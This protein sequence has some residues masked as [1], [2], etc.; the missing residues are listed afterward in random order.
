MTDLRGIKCIFVLLITLI[1][2]LNLLIPVRAQATFEYTANSDYNKMLKNTTT[3][4][5]PQNPVSKRSLLFLS[6]L[7]FFSSTSKTRIKP[8]DILTKEEALSIILNSAG[9]QQDAFLRA[10]KL[11]AKRPSGS[12]LVKPYNYLYLGYIQLA[13]DMKVISKK[14]YQDAIA[15]VQPSQKDHEKM[16]ADLIK[17]N[18]EI[19]SRAVYEGRPYSYDDL[20][21]VRSAP[22]TRQEVCR[23][24]VLT[25]KIPQSYENLARLYPDYDKIDSKFLSSINTLLKNGSLVGRS[26]GYLHPDD[27]ITYE[28]LSF[29]LYKLK[30]YIVKA[31]NL[32][33]E[34]V[35]INGVQRYSDK[36][37]ITCENDAGNNIN[38]TLSP[39]KQ[40]FVVITDNGAVLSSSLQQGDYIDLYVNNKNQ[41]V[42]GEVL[43]KAGT[44]TV[45][46]VVTKIDIKKN[47]I[48]IKL[49]DG[50]VYNL[51]VAPKATIYDTRA[52]RAINLSDLS[53]GNI[54]QTTFKKE[55]ADSITILSYQDQDINK[56]EG[57]ISLIANDKIIINSNGK[58]LSFLL[59]PD[60]AYIDKGDFT[61]M[62]TK[63]NFYQ[64]MKVLV[65]EYG[66]YA[67]Y[68]STTYDERS[69][70]VVSGILYEIDTNLNYVEIYNQDG[71]KKSYRFSKKLGLKVMKDGKLVSPDSLSKGD[72]VYLYFNGDFVRAITASSNLQPKIAK[73]EDIQRN[74]ITKMPQKIYLNIDGKVYGPYDLNSEVEVVKDGKKTSLK[75]LASGQFVKVTGSFFGMSANIKKIEISTNEYVKNIY[76]AKASIIGGNLYLSNISILRNNK[77]E[78]LYDYKTFKIPADAVFI[79]D[80]K[81][82]DSIPTLQNFSVVVIT[83][84]RFSQEVLGTVFALSKGSYSVV[85]GEVTGTSSGTILLSGEQ[86]NFSQ[87]SYIIANGLVS[88]ASLKV[89]D[90]IIAVTDGKNLVV[91]KYKE[92]VSKPIIVRGEVSEISELEYIKLKNYVYLDK[93]NGWQFVSTPLVLLY[94][95]Q[96]T[97]CDV[98]GINNP[99]DILGLLNKSVYIIHDGKYAM[100]VID[101]SFG[102][103]IVVGTMGKN[104]QVLNPQY[105]DMITKT[106]N[107]INASLVLDLS[108]AVLINSSGTIL[109]SPPQYGDDVI[110]LV[111][112]SVFD[113]SKTTVKPSVVIIN[114]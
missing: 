71:V 83:K 35:E 43:S 88:N 2:V 58:L 8:A 102:G 72:I 85:D 24:I 80:G 87:N 5:L 77:F 95:T 109:Q 106:W 19:V 114:Y 99:E 37:V 40:D 34:P 113:L 50:K 75:D 15:Q 65:G 32:K 22:A 60:T 74:P 45:K 63:N 18:N 23:W 105:Y 82:Q 108:S 38:I 70:D 7:G 110:L 16:T 112:Q 28:E 4:Q 6:A 84:D 54:V 46:G 51:L 57:V 56:I 39:P 49:S 73:I 66:G 55:R 13:Y 89:G 29:I 79:V 12:K 90:E 100:S 44:V 67:Q 3:I 36:I 30:D 111:P 42:L 101:A 93:Q 59:S 14:E 21:F 69:E 11:E 31:N 81:R 103:Y 26:D 9:K 94:D 62:L 98:Y 1:F 104:R 107:K 52:Q 17:K 27:Y 96:T 97:Y 92:A 86:F 68:I 25:L 48:Q 41:V 78:K 76:L 20:V 33:K 10:E 91:A 53:V 64:G 61:R 47:T